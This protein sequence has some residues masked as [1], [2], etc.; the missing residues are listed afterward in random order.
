MKAGSPGRE[1]QHAIRNTLCDTVIDLLMAVYSG[2]EGFASPWTLRKPRH[3]NMGCK[4]SLV[5]H[6]LKS[7]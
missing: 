6:F 4:V 1:Y 3:Q 5:R 7:H 2:V